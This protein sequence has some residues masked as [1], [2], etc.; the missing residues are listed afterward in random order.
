LQRDVHGTWLGITHQGRLAVLTN[1]REESEIV[2]GK[3]SRGELPK[4]FLGVPPESKQSSEEFAAQ[5]LAGEGVQGVGGFSLVFGQLRARHDGQAGN[6]KTGKLAVVSNRTQNAKEIVWLDEDIFGLSNSHFGDRTWPKVVQGETLLDQ[7]A[8]KDADSHGTEEELIEHCFSILSTDTLPKWQNRDDM[9]SF[10]KELRNSIFIPKIGGRAHSTAG[11]H[12]DEI[13]AADQKKEVSVTSGLYGTQKQ[14]VILV[15][16]G[17]RVTFVERTLYNGSGTN[18]LN[19]A[20]RDT[21]F[22][23]DIEDWRRY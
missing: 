5:L 17:G 1:F 15:D 8:K 4:L 3:R 16:H 9:Q 18:V 10:V 11:P 13:A 19:E 7:A 2:V 12:A 21:K 20:D 22:T 23:F 6:D 14:T